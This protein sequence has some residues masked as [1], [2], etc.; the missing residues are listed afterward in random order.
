MIRV[1]FSDLDFSM[2]LYLARE[3]SLSRGT[4][5]SRTKQSKSIAIVIA[6]AISFF[7]GGY[8]SQGLEFHPIDGP[9][10]RVATGG[11]AFS[12]RMV[13]K[14]IEARLKAGNVSFERSYRF[15]FVAERIRLFLGQ[16]A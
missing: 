4:A 15:M 1:A 11:H 14:E 12:L 5:P 2:A 10:V 9:R 7:S 8:G 16:S 13:F 3:P 6:N